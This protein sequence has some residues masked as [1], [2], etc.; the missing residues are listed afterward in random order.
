M[1]KL[2]YSIIAMTNITGDVFNNSYKKKFIRI[3]GTNIQPISDRLEEVQT[4]ASF[5]FDESEIGEWIDFFDYYYDSEKVLLCYNVVTIPNDANVTVFS[6]NKSELNLHIQ[7]FGDFY[8]DKVTLSEDFSIWENKEYCAKIF[9]KNG[10]ML[11]YLTESQPDDLVKIAVTQ[12]GYAIKYVIKKTYELCEMAVKKDG[13]SLQFIEEY[14]DTLADMAVKNNGMALKYVKLE[15]MSEN[16]CKN[17]VRQN[18]LALQYVPDI[19][20]TYKIVEIAMR[21]GN[22][23]KYAPENMKSS[24]V[25]Y[26]AGIYNPISVIYEKK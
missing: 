20:K 19:Y 22:A 16:M 6:V 13:C 17:A 25:C 12:T 11:K 26:L 24:Y 23:L 4:S 7:I 18:G 5:F 3:V 2:F 21:N 10:Y 15:F 14:H 8:S 9:E 1:Y